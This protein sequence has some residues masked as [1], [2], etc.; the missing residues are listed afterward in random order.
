MSKLTVAYARCSSSEELNRQDTEHQLFSIQQFAKVNGHTIDKV[1]EEYISAYKTA[2]E[3]R[4]Q[5]QQLLE[6]C[7][8]GLIENLY[9]FETSRLARNF[10][11]GILL[12]SD[13]SAYGVKVYSVKDNRCINQDSV[14]KLT[15]AISSYINEEASKATSQRIKSQKALAKSKGIF[16]GHKILFGYKVI[17]NENNEKIEVVDEEQAEIVKELFNIYIAQGSSKAIEYLSKYTDK[18]KN[19][20]TL[21][22]YMQNEKIQKI[23]DTDVYDMFLKT[24]QSRCTQK[25]KNVKTNRTTLKL[26]GLVFHS[27]DC[28]CEGGKLTIDFNRGKATFKCRKCKQLKADNKKSYVVEKITEQVEAEVLKLLDE[29]DKDKL[30]KY[31]DSQGNSKINFINT[32]IQTIEKSINSKKKELDK[33]NEN[34]KKML[35]LDIDVETL[36]I[37]SEV[38]KTMQQEI[39]TLND[40]LQEFKRELAIEKLKE[41]KRD[42]LVERLLD[43]RHLYKQGTEEQ[44]K[45]ILHQLIKKI[46]I[47]SND[48]IKIYYK[49]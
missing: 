49:L 15:N 5:L 22:Q 46:T 33:A 14:D 44:Q 35:L 12:L 13:F 24:K 20:F 39:N 32:Q 30:Q 23:I 3:D 48:N 18:Y 45:V 37:T 11:D 34:V 25:N 17:T 28:G 10:D 27:E 8:N 6:D 29:L 42:K 2:K 26:E 40:K 21:L 9:I 19:N 16:L 38:V 31:Y 47:D 41:D 1:Y 4:K 7:R 43:F 36:K